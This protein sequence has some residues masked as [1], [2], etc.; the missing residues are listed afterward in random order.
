MKSFFRLIWPL[1]FL[2]AS[3]SP[4]GATHPVSLTVQFA[5][6]IQAKLPEQDVFV[7]STQ[8]STQVVRI[9]GDQAADPT[10]LAKIVYATESETAHDPFKLG[11]NPLGPF[12]KGQSLGMTMESWLAA[13]G[14]G[15]YEIT[16]GNAQMHLTF[17]D[18]VP[19]GVYTVWCSR[20]TFPPRA[21]VVD[22]PCGT[23][24]GSQNK[25]TADA[26]GNGKFDLTLNPLE[27]SSIESATAIALAWHSDGQTY[28]ADPGKFGLS[29]HVQ[30]F[31]LVPVPEALT[32]TP[33]ATPGVLG[34]VLSGKAPLVI[35]LI[36]AGGIAAWYYGR[37]KSGSAAEE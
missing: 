23:A 2:L 15:T 33:P 28:G 30:L 7:V 3:V 21:Q 17:A 6:H 22:K 9:E 8:D 4:A 24:D 34:N 11:P 31:Y 27:D 32:A 13:T 1:T 5:N 18:L 12:A 29:T 16:D 26:S 14:T 37:G 36:V 20:I 25:F 10:T 35:L 19:E